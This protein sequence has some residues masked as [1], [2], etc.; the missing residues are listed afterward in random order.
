MATSNVSSDLRH[1]QLVN[2]TISDKIF[3]PTHVLS[4]I[5]PLGESGEIL[6]PFPSALSLES[7]L[8]EPTV[9]PDI[10]RGS[11]GKEKRGGVDGGEGFDKRF[12]FLLSTSH[13]K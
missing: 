8:G 9:R 2:T 12:H 1:Y 10:A 3:L 6:C 7:P 5:K 4:V 13:R 11:H